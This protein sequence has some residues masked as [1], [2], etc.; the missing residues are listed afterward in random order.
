ML[1]EYSQ[2]C[3]KVKLLK[4]TFKKNKKMSERLRDATNILANAKDFAAA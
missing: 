1:F 2:L 3:F 4:A